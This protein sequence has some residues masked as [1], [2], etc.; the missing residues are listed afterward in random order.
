VVPLRGGRGAVLRKVG[1]GGPVEGVSP[2]TG[3]LCA[4]S[5][6]A[7]HAKHTHICK[8][9]T[10]SLLLDRRSSPRRRGRGARTASC[11]IAASRD[12]GPLRLGQ[13]YPV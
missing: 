7:S 6:A 9:Y 5:G 2:V 12:G 13:S 1:A 4:V 11:H 8:L 3:A 10:V